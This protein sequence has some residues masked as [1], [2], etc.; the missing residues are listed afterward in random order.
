M[1]GQVLEVRGCRAF[2]PDGHDQ[3]QTCC[4]L[5]TLPLRKEKTHL[6]F[7]RQKRQVKPPT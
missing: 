5:S 6:M 3:P 1:H 7:G 2:E 4:D